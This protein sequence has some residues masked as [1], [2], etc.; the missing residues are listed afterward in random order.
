MDSKN[1]RRKAT[2]AKNRK[3]QDNKLKLQKSQARLKKSKQRQLSQ[4][5]VGATFTATS[6]KKISR[7]KRHN[8]AE[9]ASESESCGFQLLT[10]IKGIFESRKVKKLKTKSLLLYLCS[11][12]KKP[13]A[14]FCGGQNL[15]SRRL[16]TLL[17]EFGLHSKDIRFKKGVFKGFLKKNIVAAW[18]S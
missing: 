17:K 9:K 2:V 18:N 4:K 1:R 7:P 3:V 5:K 12:Q 13:W 10:D 16:S 15:N 14:K 6:N 8:T 11:D